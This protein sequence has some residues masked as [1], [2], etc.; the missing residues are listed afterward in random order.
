ML[1]NMIGCLEVDTNN[2]CVSEDNKESTR[3]RDKRAYLLDGD[4]RSNPELE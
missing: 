1:T 2:S 4:T 3:N